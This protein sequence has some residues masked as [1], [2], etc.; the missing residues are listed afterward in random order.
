[1]L[2]HLRSLGFC[3]N[4]LTVY[5]CFDDQENLKY[6]V[7]DVTNTPWGERHQ[8]VMPYMNSKE[9]VFTKD[10]HVSPFLPMDLHYKV[11]MTAPNVTTVVHMENH[12]PEKMVFDATLTLSQTP[13]NAEE[14]SKVALQ[15]AFMTYKVVLW[16]YFQ[17]F[18]LFFV[19][20]F[21][22][23]SHPGNGS[24]KNHEGASL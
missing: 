10:F 20:R 5:Y 2:T 17:A 11:R 12:D 19:R 13:V 23:Y 7:L 1:M 16:I 22:F 3:F 9:H 6:L 21:K 4:P 14:I 24:N 18:I 8:Y 15:H